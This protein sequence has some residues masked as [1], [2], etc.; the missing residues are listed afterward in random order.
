LGVPG[1]IVEVYHVVAGVVA[2]VVLDHVVVV[3]L[4]PR[5]GHELAE[6]LSGGRRTATAGACSWT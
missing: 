1:G 6:A 4:V 5:L 2:D 3:D